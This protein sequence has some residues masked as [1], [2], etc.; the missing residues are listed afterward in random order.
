MFWP[1]RRPGTQGH[2]FAIY[3]CPYFPSLY[4]GHSQSA[5]FDTK[6]TKTSIQDYRRAYV[7][8][9]SQCEILKNI[10]EHLIIIYVCKT[11]FLWLFS[12]LMLYTKNESSHRH[13]TEFVTLMDKLMH[14]HCYDAS[15]D[16]L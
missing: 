3:E 2:A 8:K 13:E 1:C 11:V 5:P 16:N 14:F 4:C 7:L 10:K 15:S 12:L 6:Q 9:Q